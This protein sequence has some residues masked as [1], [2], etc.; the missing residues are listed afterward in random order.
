MD[1]LS[2][3]HADRTKCSDLVIKRAKRFFVH[4]NCC[5]HNLGVEY[6]LLG[7]TSESTNISDFPLDFRGFFIPKILII[8]WDKK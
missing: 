5:K 7:S 2:A 1:A 8:F 6:I 3:R 4:K